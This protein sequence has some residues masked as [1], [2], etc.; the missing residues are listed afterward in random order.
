MLVA[1]ATNQ[2]AVAVISQHVEEQ[3][4]PAEVRK[5]AALHA[6][7]QLATG[8]QVQ[9]P[10]T[11][12]QAKPAEAPRK[13][14]VTQGAHIVG[15]ALV[16]AGGITTISGFNS[17]E[18]GWEPFAIVV[19]GIILAVVGGAMLLFKGKTARRRQKRA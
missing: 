18:P 5:Q 14:G 1:S 10:D 4:R 2:P 19:L 16:L 3:T 15:G 7:N 12:L 11:L 9:S 17:N 8:L 13:F 6:P